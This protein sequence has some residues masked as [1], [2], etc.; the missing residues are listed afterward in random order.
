MTCDADG[1]WQARVRSAIDYPDEANAFCFAVEEQS[2]WF[3]YRNRFII[4]AVRRFPPDGP[5]ADIGAGNGF[6]ALGLERAG[7]PTLVVEPG[8]AGAKNARSRGLNPVVCATLS[9]AG[10]VPESFAAAGLFDVV[11]HMDDARGFLTMTRRLMKPGARL[12]VTVPAFDALWSTEDELVGHH[13]RYS[14]RTL[15]DTLAASGFTVDYATYLFAP[16]ALPLFLLRTLP[17]RL[18]R[19]RTLDPARTAAELKPPAGPAVRAITL[20]LDREVN[21]VRQGRT[22]AFGTTCLA[23]ARSLGV[24]PDP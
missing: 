14:I 16:L 8:R 23:V 21:R 15:G 24:I 2:F 10:F 5:I 22:I 6:V 11:E 18:G 3:D 4:E 12:Y 19:R 7:F 13:R 9:D 17:S 1:I 20:L